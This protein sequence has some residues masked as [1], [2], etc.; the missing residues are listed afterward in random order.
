MIGKLDQKI[1]IERKTKTSDGAGGFKSDWTPLADDPEPFAKVTLEGGGEGQVGGG[2]QSRQRAKFVIRARF[3][4]R[5]GD[6]II[7]GG[8]EWNIHAKGS[9]VARS[10]YQTL[11]AA[12][13]SLDV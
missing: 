9:P 4:L 3:D 5:T 12:T 2:T 6:R 1:R 7:W 13:G 10:L 8:F 11:H